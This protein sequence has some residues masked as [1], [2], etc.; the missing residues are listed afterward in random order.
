VRARWL[1]P[2]FFRDRKMAALG[3]GPALLYAA[4]WV[5]ADDGG[6]APCDPDRLKGE[7]F[8]A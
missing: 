1:K 5:S 7:L 3:V 2:E 8:Y 6:V 4:L